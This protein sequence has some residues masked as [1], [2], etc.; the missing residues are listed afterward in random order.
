LVLAYDLLEDRRTIDVI[1]SKFFPRFFSLIKMA[2]SFENLEDVL[3]DWANDDIEGS[4]AQAVTLFEK[5]EEQKTRFFVEDNLQNIL[6]ESQSKATKRNT[7]WVVKLFQGKAP[8]LCFAFNKLKKQ[9]VCEINLFQKFNFSQSQNICLHR[10]VL[11]KK[12]HN[13]TC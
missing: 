8:V 3:P 7:K 12:H 13:T 10:L 4:L 11:G 9:D 2:E 6:E 5:Q 1:I